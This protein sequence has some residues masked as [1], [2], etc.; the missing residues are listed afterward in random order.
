MVEFFFVNILYVY[1]FKI[2]MKNYV[3]FL[4]L[5]NFYEII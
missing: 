1:I 4:F 3:I 2:N 5:C